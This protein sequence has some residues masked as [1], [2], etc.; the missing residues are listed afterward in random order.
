MGNG[1]AVRCVG[2]LQIDAFSFRAFVITLINEKRFEW[3][4]EK[5]T[6]IE[7]AG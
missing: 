5:R 6:T 1:W 3:L 2:Y 7:M 4:L